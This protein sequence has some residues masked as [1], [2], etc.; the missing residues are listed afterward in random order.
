MS[1]QCDKCDGTGWYGDNG[2]GILGNTEFVECDCGTTTKCMVGSHKYRVIDSVAWCDTCN[3]EVDVTV[4][5]LSHPLSFDEAHVQAMNEL[6]AH[7]GPTTTLT[8]NILRNWSREKIQ[9]FASHLIGD[10][11]EDQW[12]MSQE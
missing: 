7:D 4:C 10:T 6:M 5:K 2:P 12:P 3:L 8:A 11:K 1:E 9:R